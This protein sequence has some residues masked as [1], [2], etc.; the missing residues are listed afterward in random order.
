MVAHTHRKM[1]SG[2]RPHTGGAHRDETGVLIV[3]LGRRSSARPKC[4]FQI[5]LQKGHWWV[6]GPIRTRTLWRT[7]RTLW[8]TP[9]TPY[10]PLDPP[11]ERY[12]VG[13][14]ITSAPPPPPPLWARASHGLSCLRRTHQTADGPR[15]GS[16][17]RGSDA[18]SGASQGRASS[19]ITCWI[20]RV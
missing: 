2:T 4:I 16:E 7:P 18:G 9:T 8:S 17:V 13:V 15:F 5:R 1:N 6:C 10:P 19:H 20:S 14:G 3:V 11:N 12:T